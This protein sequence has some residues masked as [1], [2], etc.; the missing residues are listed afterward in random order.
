MSQINVH[1]AH[2]KF[3]ASMVFSEKEL[4]FVAIINST[5]CLSLMAGF[6]RSVT[7]RR[8]VIKFLI[9]ASIVR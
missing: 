5:Q 9:V 2:A 4:T 6:C 3:T 1:V 8:E 7:A